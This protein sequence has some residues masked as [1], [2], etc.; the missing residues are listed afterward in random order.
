MPIAPLVVVSTAV[1]I[2]DWAIKIYCVYI[3]H[4]RSG[5]KSSRMQDTFF[6]VILYGMFLGTLFI[7]DQ[8]FI[9]TACLALFEVIFEDSTAKLF[10]QIQLTTIGTLMIIVREGRSVDENWEETFGYS[11]L[12]SIASS[13][14]WLIKLK[15][16]FTSKKDS[17][18]K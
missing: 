11:P 13:F 14:G 8:F 3:K 17:S 4:G 12:D 6:K 1:A 5:I 9:K 16:G 2:F 10:T 18:N 7:V 15:D